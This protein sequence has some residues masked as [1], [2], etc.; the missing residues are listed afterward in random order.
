MNLGP[1]LSASPYHKSIEQMYKNL[2]SIRKNTG[3]SAK[4]NHGKEEDAF[5]PYLTPFAAPKAPAKV[6]LDLKTSISHYMDTSTSLAEPS[7]DAENGF[8]VASGMVG[9]EPR[10]VSYRI[11]EIMGV[12][13]S[14]DFTVEATGQ[15][16]AVFVPTTE[17]LSELLRLIRLRHKVDDMRTLCSWV[18]TCIVID[19]D[20]MTIV[21]ASFNA[22]QLHEVVASTLT[23]MVH[24]Y[25]VKIQ[26]LIRR[27]LSNTR[28]AKAW[29]TK[30]QLKKSQQDAMKRARQ[31]LEQFQA[32]HQSLASPATGTAAANST[33]HTGGR[34]G[35]RL[36]P[37]ALNASRV[38]HRR[39]ELVAFSPFQLNSHGAAGPGDATINTL[40][41]GKM[42]V[43]RGMAPI[44]EQ[45]MAAVAPPRKGSRMEPTPPTTSAP[46]HSS[47]IGLRRPSNAQPIISLLGG[48]A[49]GYGN[50]SAISE[51][52][53]GKT[54]QQLRAL[55]RDLTGQM[56]FFEDELM[57]IKSELEEQKLT[58]FYSRGT[59]YKAAL[60]YTPHDDDETSSNQER[61]PSGR[62]NR[63][64]AFKDAPNTSFE[65]GTA[66]MEAVTTH[67]SLPSTAPAAVEL[68]QLKTKF[69][70]LELE[71]KE[72]KQ[73][74][75]E[76]ARRET[77]DFST[78]QAQQEHHVRETAER[79]AKEQITQLE[80]DLAQRE[81]QIRDLEKRLE[82]V[83]VE[84]VKAH[85]STMKR[86][87]ALIEKERNELVEK[88]EGM[89]RELAELMHQLHAKQVEQAGALNQAQEK[90]SQQQQQQQQQ[91]QSQ[92]QRQKETI[93]QLQSQ[94]LAVQE[95]VMRPVPPPGSS[96]RGGSSRGGGGGGSGGGGGGSGRSRGRTLKPSDGRSSA[97]L[98]DEE[99]VENVPPSG[100]WSWLIRNLGFGRGGSSGSSGGNARKSSTHASNKSSPRRAPSSA[101][102]N[103]AA[104][105]AAATATTAGGAGAVGGGG[106]GASNKRGSVQGSF[107]NGVDGGGGDGNSPEGSPN[108]R[109]SFQLLDPRRSM[110][111]LTGSVL[112]SFT[113]QPGGGGGGGGNADDGAQEASEH[114]GGGGVGGGGDDD[115]MGG[116]MKLLRPF[117]DLTRPDEEEETSAMVRE[118]ARQ[119]EETQRHDAARAIQW[120]FRDYA[121]RTCLTKWPQ[122]FLEYQYEVLRHGATD[123]SIATAAAAAVT[124]ASS[125]TATATMSAT[126]AGS[127]LAKK[128]AAFFHARRLIHVPFSLRRLF[129][130]HGGATSQPAVLNRALT[131]AVRGLQALE[132]TV[133]GSSSSP[134]PT[135]GGGPASSSMLR[136]YGFT[137]QEEELL[138]RLMALKSDVLGEAAASAASSASGGGGGGGDVFAEVSVEDLTALSSI[139]TLTLFTEA[140][141]Q[142]IESYVVELNSPLE[143]LHVHKLLYVIMAMAR[144]AEAR[145]MEEQELAGLLPS[146]QATQHGSVSVKAAPQQPPSSSAA[147]GGGGG[148]G[149]ANLASLV[150]HLAPSTMTLTRPGRL[151]RGKSMGKHGR[152]G[153]HHAT[154][155][156]QWAQLRRTKGRRVPGYHVVHDDHE[157][158]DED[159]I[160]YFPSFAHVP[161]ATATEAAWDQATAAAADSA[162][163]PQEQ[164]QQPPHR[165][166]LRA[167]DVSD[168]ARL[169]RVCSRGLY[170]L[171]Q[172]IKTQPSYWE[173]CGLSKTAFKEVYAFF[174]ALSRVL[175]MPVVLWA[176]MADVYICGHAFRALYLLLCCPIPA[177]YRSLLV[178]ADLVLGLRRCL[179]QFQV[180]AT[181]PGLIA[182]ASTTN[183]TTA[184]TAPAA[185]GVDV[186]ECLLK[187]LVNL[188]IDNRRA[189]DLFAS[190]QVPACLLMS[191]LNLHDDHAPT[192]RLRNTRFMILHCRALINLCALDHRGN[193]TM[194]GRGMFPTIYVKMLLIHAAKIQAIE[195]ELFH[196]SSSSTY[197]ENDAD[198]Q[199]YVLVEQLL[200]AI[201]AMALNHEEN[202]LKLQTAGICEVLLDVL[203]AQTTERRQRR[204]QHQQ[205]QQQHLLAAEK[206]RKTVTATTATTEA[207]PAAAAAQPT[208]PMLYHDARQTLV[209]T[210]LWALTH[211]TMQSAAYRLVH[212]RVL[213]ALAALQQAQEAPEDQFWAQE[214]HKAFTRLN[215]LAAQQ[216]PSQSQSQASAAVSTAIQPLLS[217][218][219]HTPYHHP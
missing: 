192:H 32:M 156:D 128:P 184:T 210:L 155:A 119:R 34:R 126:A 172:V 118:R 68:E 179:E 40:L 57:Q 76:V 140:V 215:Q 61:T 95:A 213:Q 83:M 169:K 190:H 78:L 183:T 157:E 5:L 64:H 14:V 162:S 86:Q 17:I 146:A 105:A 124:A 21:G 204:I 206:K 36:F 3:N 38:R 108:R 142:A 137:A 74:V 178:N 175:T 153:N 96:S 188:C 102:M 48:A 46:P 52:G 71:L 42:A 53:G 27:F 18:L 13:F 197:H 216:Q 113:G 10:L 81:E 66:D 31:R 129:F 94:Y 149:N 49:A 22:K 209:S 107:S 67:G 15:T 174:R 141:L 214:A 127:S 19:F 25:A 114:H 158:P 193:Q 69:S 211:L 72:Q 185:D 79:V 163:T 41:K 139:R 117:E 207:T 150:T 62:R 136:V 132:A 121:R 144:V 120:A 91:W 171:H 93:A 30:K 1:L 28:L 106:V 26:A 173:H 24:H 12:C 133:A 134:S 187:A 180:K 29:E 11:R 63:S 205:Q 131:Y 87:E 135:E 77:E 218:P 4:G 199:E 47:V 166:L 75:D 145:W 152:L 170:L 23:K 200:R 212:Q 164:Q 202:K 217:S 143:E 20:D 219:L 98:Q 92:I 73:H 110:Q 59:E 112:G 50:S 130:Q 195:N 82:H 115:I 186:L 109:Q 85:S 148:K 203:H 88:Q 84:Q 58:L 33:G 8:I 122:F 198:R 65:R 151:T 154:V 147:A 100:M 182:A 208:I 165:A 9:E 181:A 43:A 39:S 99:S 177:L 111:L 167:E 45:A 116:F 101:N 160:V 44:P 2:Q 7:T 103:A 89:K 16:W 176:P 56:S 97:S 123:P 201:V 54:E 104:A 138:V 189:Q 51:Y 37:A 159:W 161:A 6:N 191:L 125:S 35:T 168:I 80:D 90:W 70:Q 196:A 55:R 194:L 60:K